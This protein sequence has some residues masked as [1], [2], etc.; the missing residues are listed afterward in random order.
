[1]IFHRFVL[2]TLMSLL[3]PL[4]QGNNV[5]VS[6]LSKRNQS[7][8]DQ[9]EFV[10]HLTTDSSLTPHQLLTSYSTGKFALLPRLGAN[11]KKTLQIPGSHC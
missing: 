6:D 7:F 10:Y 2:F 11:Y 1:M 4:A 3:T 5:P 9:N 8:H